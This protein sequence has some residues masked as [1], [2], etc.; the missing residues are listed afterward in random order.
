MLPSLCSLPI[1]APGYGA[2]E[3][4]FA[5]LYARARKRHIPKANPNECMNGCVLDD[6]GRALTVVDLSEQ[7]RLKTLQKLHK[8]DVAEG[9]PRFRNGAPHRLN[10]IPPVAWRPLLEDVLT[11]CSP[12]SGQ[13]ATD[14]PMRE[15]AVA[16]EVA[17]ARKT[18]LV[19]VLKEAIDD[20]PKTTSALEFTHFV[21]YVRSAVRASKPLLAASA[22]VSAAWAMR[23]LYA[24]YLVKYEVEYEQV[25]PPLV[26]FDRGRQLSAVQQHYSS[27][28]ASVG[29]AHKRV[30]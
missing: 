12:E 8:R 15:D 24:Y 17:L 25:V 22:V 6:K 29:V 23:A 10:P 2:L 26:W 20:V 1:G 28:V 3:E 4:D 5:R 21:G 16:I 13:L 7:W 14:S 18:R 30:V 11:T 9:H 27:G 19:D